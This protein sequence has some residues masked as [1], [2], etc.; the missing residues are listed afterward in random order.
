MPSKRRQLRYLGFRLVGWLAWLPLTGD[1]WH[2][3]TYGDLQRLGPQRAAVLL[4]PI[5]CY[6]AVAAWA[7]VYFPRELLP[8]AGSV[9]AAGLFL[10]GTVVASTL[11]ATKL[12]AWDL[13]RR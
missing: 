4:V 9:Y 10:G 12:V 2:D 11:V 13:V 8:F 5:A 3:R 6:A 7:Y 1:P